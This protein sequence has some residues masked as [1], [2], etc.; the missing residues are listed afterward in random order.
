MIASGDTHPFHSEEYIGLA[1]TT[2]DLDPAMSIDDDAWVRGGLPKRSM[3]KPWQPTLLKHDDTV[4]AFGLL[5]ASVVDR[6]TA[7]LRAVLDD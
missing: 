2:T 4:D 5:Q 6:A 7:K 3:I 1:I